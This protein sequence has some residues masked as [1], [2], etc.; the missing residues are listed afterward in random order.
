[1]QM[2][3]NFFGNN[4]SSWREQPESPSAGTSLRSRFVKTTG[5]S[6]AG[7]A[8]RCVTSACAFGAITATHCKI[9]ESAGQ[10]VGVERPPET[11]AA[12]LSC[13]TAWRDLHAVASGA[14]PEFLHRLLPLDAILRRAAVVADRFERSRE[15]AARAPRA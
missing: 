4:G 10:I 13:G 14:P 15:D 6:N 7:V 2:Y 12:A 5:F 1:M 3:I 9:P 8:S 11:W